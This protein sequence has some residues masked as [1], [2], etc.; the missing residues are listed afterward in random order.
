MQNIIAIAIL[1][2]SFIGML[3]IFLRKIP[4]M[5]EYVPPAVSKPPRIN[6][7]KSIKVFPDALFWHKFLSKFRILVLKTD[8][9]TSE[10]MK[11]L[12]EKSIENKTKFSDNYWEKLR[13]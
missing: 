10:W 4:A 3:V 6:K 1:I 13:K 8:N 7:I 2:I 9:K 5:A 11:R 12:R